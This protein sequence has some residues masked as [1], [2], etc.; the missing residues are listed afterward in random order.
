MLFLLLS[1]KN[2]N[3]KIRTDYV[4]YK[5]FMEKQKPNVTV[6]S[7]HVGALSGMC[8]LGKMFF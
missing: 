7:L 6:N 4:Y 8:W 3:N 2:W 1:Q 5:C